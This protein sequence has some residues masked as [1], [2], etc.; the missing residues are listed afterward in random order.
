[1]KDAM[2]NNKKECVFREAEQKSFGRILYH[3]DNENADK[4]LAILRRK[5]LSGDK[6]KELEN[7]GLRIRIVDK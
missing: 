2:K 7:I 6:L 5:H 3:P 4:I 1:M